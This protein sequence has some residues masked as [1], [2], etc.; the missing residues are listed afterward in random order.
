M[1]IMLQVIGIGKELGLTVKQRSGLST[2][3]MAQLR[4]M[5]RCNLHTDTNQTSKTVITP[6]PTRPVRSYHTD[7]NQ[8]SKTVITP[9]PT[10][11]VRQ[12][13]HQHQ[14]DQ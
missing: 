14:P 1:M 8:T 10:R 6:T 7:T 2:I 4:D 3:D 11:P 5:Y 9:T 12:L 13:S